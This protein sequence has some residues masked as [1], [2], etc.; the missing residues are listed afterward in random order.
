[1][2]HAPLNLDGAARRV[3]DAAELDQEAVTQHLE[4]PPVKPGDRGIEELAAVLL[5]RAQRALLVG[6]HQPAVTD[7]VRREDSSEPALQVLLVQTSHSRHSE[8]P[9]PD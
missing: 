6:L 8:Q 4:D 9:I 2:E 1:M 7:D 3:E 5:Q